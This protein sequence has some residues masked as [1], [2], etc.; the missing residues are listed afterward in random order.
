MLSR[1]LDIKMSD[2]SATSGHQIHRKDFVSMVAN[3]DTDGVRAFDATIY[4]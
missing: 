3:V 4:N 2:M 1:A